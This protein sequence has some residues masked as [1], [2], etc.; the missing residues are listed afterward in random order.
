MARLRPPSGIRMSSAWHS[1]QALAVLLYTAVP[2]TLGHLWYYQSVRAVGPGRAAAFMN[3]MPFAILGLSW[4]LLGDTIHW[5]H[6]LGATVVIA[7]V[8][9]VT[10]K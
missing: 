4:A 9:L 10:G 8:V 7:G 1:W 6:A 2:V 5:Y 3:L